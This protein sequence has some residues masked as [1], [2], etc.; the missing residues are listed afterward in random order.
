MGYSVTPLTGTVDNSITTIRYY[1]YIRYLYSHS[2]CILNL[3]I[4]LINIQMKPSFLSLKS[5]TEFPL[6]NIP[7]GIICTLSDVSIL[8]VMAVI[9]CIVLFCIYLFILY[10]LIDFISPRPEWLPEWGIPWWI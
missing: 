6:E 10:L 1:Y 7:F 5:D 4:N 8:I 2:L 3:N 9:G